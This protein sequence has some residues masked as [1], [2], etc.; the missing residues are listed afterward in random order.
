[1]ESYERNNGMDMFC[2]YY[3]DCNM[4]DNDTLVISRMD[5]EKGIFEKW[6]C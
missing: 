5:L 3:R 6:V 2:R 4:F 1:M